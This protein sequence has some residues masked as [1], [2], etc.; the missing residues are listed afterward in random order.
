MHHRFAPWIAGALLG[1]LLLAPA[2]AR[3]HSIWVDPRPRD[4]DDGHKDFNGGAPCGGVK[5]VD[6][7]PDR[8]YVAGGKATIKWD[9]AINHAGCFVIG[10]SAADDKDFRQLLVVPHDNTPPDPDRGTPPRHYSAT[11][12]LPKDIVCDKCTLQ[13]RMLMVSGKCPPDPIMPNTTYY[14]CADI[15]IAEAPDLGA[16]PDLS[17]PPAPDL[18]APPAP[19]LA[20]APMPAHG[21]RAAPGAS[22][23]PA[24]LAVLG[25]LALFRHKKTRA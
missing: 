3:A 9:E 13:L 15:R 25:L 8:H 23:D 6:N 18:S 11:V 19:D 5:R 4:N 2:P 1:A 16:A 17:T 10:L 22:A 24:G 14:S 20:T 21:C 12:E 7:N